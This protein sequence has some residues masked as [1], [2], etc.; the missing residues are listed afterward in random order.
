MQVPSTVLFT[1][2]AR[3]SLADHFNS[4]GRDLRKVPN[5]KVGD[6]LLQDRVNFYQLHGGDA[7]DQPD[8]YY[9]GVGKWRS[10]SSRERET[11]YSIG[12][13]ELA[14]AIQETL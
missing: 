3:L 5:I 8:P 2:R 10:C 12:Y 11:P 7:E 9:P 14:Y 4:K 13:V 6:I 1:Y